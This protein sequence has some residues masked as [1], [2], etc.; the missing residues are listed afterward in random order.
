M[1][2]IAREILAHYRPDY[3]KFECSR[4]YIRHWQRRT[5]NPFPASRKNNTY[6]VKECLDWVREY[7][8]KKNGLDDKDANLM[9]RAAEA[10]ARKKIRLNDEHE[11]DFKVKQAMYIL[12]R[13][14]EIAAIG[15]AKRFLAITRDEIRAAF[16]KIDVPRGEEL[17]DALDM[18]YKE[19]ANE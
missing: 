13:E 4:E 19:A 2:G 5:E 6:N 14:A 8:I 16:L 17:I 10:V 18:K 3:P 9:Q 15:L 7:V 12:K 1:A 11:F